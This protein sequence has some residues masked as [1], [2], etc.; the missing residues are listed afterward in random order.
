MSE[1]AELEQRQQALTLELESLQREAATRGQ[2]LQDTVGGELAEFRELE[3][4]VATAEGEVRALGFEV[5]RLRTEE[6]EL[7]RLLDS[8]REH[9]RTLRAA[10]PPPRQPVVYNNTINL[11]LGVIGFIGVLLVVLYAAF[12]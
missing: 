10:G 9:L 11:V 3:A 7:R 12:H 8:A 4:S 2:A 6:Q 5:E 1:L